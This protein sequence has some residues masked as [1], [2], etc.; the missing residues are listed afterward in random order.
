MQEKLKGESQI[1]SFDLF[2]ISIAADYGSIRN[3][4]CVFEVKIVIWNLQAISK[5]FP[6]SASKITRMWLHNVRKEIFKN[7]F[8]N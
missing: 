3:D 6:F 2:P 7:S 4:S 1:E 8:T 5:F